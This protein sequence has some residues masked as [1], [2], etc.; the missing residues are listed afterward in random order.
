MMVLTAD[1]ACPYCKMLP[2]EQVCNVTVGDSRWFFFLNILHWLF[3]CRALQLQLRGGGG[4]VIAVDA[5]FI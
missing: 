5:L 1:Q 3:C 2:F 4:A